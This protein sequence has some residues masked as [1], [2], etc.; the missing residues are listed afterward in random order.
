MRRGGRPTRGLGC[1]APPFPGGGGGGQETRAGPPGLA[2]AGRGREQAGLGGIWM[3]PL[4][5]TG[6]FVRPAR[7]LACST[8]ALVLPFR[9]GFRGPILCPGRGPCAI[10]ARHAPVLAGSGASQTRV[11]RVA[12]RL[13]RAPRASAPRATRALPGPR[14]GPPP[15]GATCRFAD[16]RAGDWCGGGGF[17]VQSRAGRSY[18]KRQSVLNGHVARTDGRMAASA[19]SDGP[20]RPSGPLATRGYSSLA[21]CAGCHRALQRALLPGRL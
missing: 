5:V 13:K 16:M 20:S 4:S 8:G 11:G 7:T 6:Q 19:E 1:A 9:F 17:R 10:A 21:S 3:L 2:R 12:P 15:A 14:S 18:G